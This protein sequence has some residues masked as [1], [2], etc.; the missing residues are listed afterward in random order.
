MDEFELIRRFFYGDSS[1]GVTLGIG[2]DAAL[3][4]PTPHHSLVIA[5]DTMVEGVHYP[6]GLAAED[7]GY[8]L[9]AVNLSDMAAMGAMPRWMLLSLG[10]ATADT[11]WLNGFSHGLR[12]AAAAHGVPLVGGDTVR[13]PVPTLTLTMVGETAPGHALLRSGARPG[14]TIYVSGHPGD[15]AGGLDAIRNGA[16]E[17]ALTRAFKRPA[18]RVLLGQA[19]SGHAKAAIDV[20]DGLLG[21]LEKLAAASGLG[22]VIDVDRLPLSSDL[23]DTFGIERARELALNGGDDY[24]L[25]FTASSRLPESIASEVTAIGRIG[26]AEGGVSCRLDGES[27]SAAD[28]SYRH[29]T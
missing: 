8:R 5:C 1:P 18:S 21:D 24:E 10:I 22:A 19:L 4:A 2:D 28:Q 27:W 29:F 16:C 9:V 3:L 11:D 12:E 14:D 26:D 6:S 17:N 25:L 23:I 15:A 13:T 20:S 7:V